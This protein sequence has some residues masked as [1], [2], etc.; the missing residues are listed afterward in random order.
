M[1]LRVLLLLALVLGMAA[2][3][4]TA[5]AQAPP[6]FTVRNVEVDQTAN[7]AAEAREAAFAE[8]QR[9][10]F[11]Q[12]LERLTPRAQQNRLPRATA[13]Q[14]A[15]L[16][17]NFEVQSERA[18]A[19]RYIATYTFRFNP[20]GIRTLLRR[21]NVPFSETYARPLVVLPV[22]H[23]GDVA[24]LWDEPNPWLAAWRALP[25]SDGLQPLIVPLGDLSD[26]GMIS[27]DQAQRGDAER[28]AGIA[29]KYGA[30]GVVLVEA[31]I[32]RSAAG[33][34]VA[35]VATTRFDGSGDQ[36]LVESYTAGAGEEADAL[37]V[38]A[39]AQTANAIEEQW[40]SDVALQFG[41]EA[42]LVTEVVFAALADW[43]AMRERLAETA[44]IRRTEVLNLSRNRAQL[45]LHFIG[46][47]SGLRLAL[48]Q[49]DL[50][51]DR[52]NAGWQLS[53]RRG[54]A[55]TPTRP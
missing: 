50:V 15:D 31:L 43:V 51:L 53:L 37:L 4:S 25:P 14:I 26:I 5:A 17:E 54:A 8:G 9:K 6:V 28:V 22:Y 38:R 10:A 32:D 41:Q 35:Q 55:Q 20:D 2:A 47:E 13:A 16:I 18:S 52:D 48:A 11:R 33:R 44:M 39:A 49:K 46:S 1:M 3:S 27:A 24:V 29:G 12:L 36:T 42:S 19:V 21:A 23:E 40:K 45:E 30:G 7:T 34:V